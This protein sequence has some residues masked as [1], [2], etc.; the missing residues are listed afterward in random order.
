MP[1]KYNPIEDENKKFTLRE[2]VELLKNE[3]DVYLEEW[4]GAHSGEASTYSQWMN[5]FIRLMSW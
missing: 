2:W 4:E 3:L 5:L 1:Y